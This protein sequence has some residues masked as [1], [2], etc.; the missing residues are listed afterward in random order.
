MQ[1]CSIIK[2]KLPTTLSSIVNMVELDLQTL[3]IWALKLKFETPTFSGEIGLGG[4]VAAVYFKS[5]GTDY[6]QI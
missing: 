1:A 3:F 6:M 4:I 2:A 5:E